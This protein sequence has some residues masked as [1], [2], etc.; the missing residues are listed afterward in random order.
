MSL[1]HST[2]GSG[3]VQDPNFELQCT[4]QQDVKHLTQTTMPYTSV[5]RVGEAEKCWYLSHTSKLNDKEL[6]V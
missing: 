3:A 5:I 1:R 4:T 2:V 6:T